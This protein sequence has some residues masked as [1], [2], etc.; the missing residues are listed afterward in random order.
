MTK[1]MDNLLRLATMHIHKKEAM[2][3][4]LNLHCI[5]RQACISN[6]HTHFL[7]QLFKRRYVLE[8][9]LLVLLHPYLNNNDELD[10]NFQLIH[11]QVEY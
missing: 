7:L 11:T 2:S 8:F 3:F 4:I 10:V 5:R 1:N 6:F 9:L